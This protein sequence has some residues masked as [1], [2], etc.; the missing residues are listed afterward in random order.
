MNLYF[1]DL[2]LYLYMYLYFN[3]L[4]VCVNQDECA[5]LGFL[6]IQSGDWVRLIG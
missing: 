2:Y 3:V 6:S 5:A 1:N 4:A